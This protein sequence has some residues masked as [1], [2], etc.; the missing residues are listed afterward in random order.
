MFTKTLNILLI[1]LADQIQHV[2]LINCLDC[3][4]G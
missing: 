3:T 4:H 2:Q 1:F